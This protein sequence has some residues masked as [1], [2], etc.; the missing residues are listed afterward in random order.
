[1]ALT[2]IRHAAVPKEYRGR[3][4]GWSDISI[5]IESFNKQTV[6]KI[7][8]KHFQQVYSS[9]LSR[10]TDTLK[11]LG[12]EEFDT[13]R[14]L[15]EVRFKDWAECKSF[16]EISQREDFN[17]SYLESMERWHKYIAYESLKEFRSRIESFLSETDSQKEILIC[18]HAGVIRE[19][20]SIHGYDTNIEIGYLSMME[21]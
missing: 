7:Q 9:D 19:I 1:M 5:D 18:T 2:L 4:I 3:Y 15:R 12:F 20:L 14:R 17:E 16:D 8:H 21:L 13:D 10:C 11:L 6:E